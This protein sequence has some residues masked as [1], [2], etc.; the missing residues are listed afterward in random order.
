MYK[1]LVTDYARLLK[2]LASISAR[3]IYNDVDENKCIVD[4]LK[5]YFE[6]SSCD[7]EKSNAEHAKVTEDEFNA[8]INNAEEC[9]LGASAFDFENVPYCAT[10]TEEN[11]LMDRIKIVRDTLM[12]LV[13]YI[14][15]NKNTDLA[16]CYDYYNQTMHNVKVIT[17]VYNELSMTVFKDFQMESDVERMNKWLTKFRDMGMGHSGHSLWKAM[18]YTCELLCKL[19]KFAIRLETADCFHISLA[20]IGACIQDSNLLLKT[21]SYPEPIIA[22][23]EVFTKTYGWSTY[24]WADPVIDED[25]QTE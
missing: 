6:D 8:M 25:T 14:P 23:R 18:N 24:N 10:Y 11:E 13:N 7:C 20:G 19:N 2:D 4:V 22:G 1:D 9:I 16:K 15:Y 21:V 5:D 12:P 17:R 3:I